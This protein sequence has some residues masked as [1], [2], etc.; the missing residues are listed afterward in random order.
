M[1]P[2]LPLLSPRSRGFLPALFAL[3]LALLAS[4]T[5][6]AVPSFARQTGADCAACHVGAYGPQ[7]TP[8]GIQFKLGGY[9]DTDGKDG[10]LPLSVMAVFNATRSAKDLPEDPGHGYHLNNNT[11]L[12]EASV[13]VAGRIAE[14]LGGFSQVT[15]SGIEHK[16]ALDQVDLR[17]ARNVKLGESEALAG[18]SFN[19]NPTLTDPFNSIGQWAFPYVESD[20]G[21]GQGNT[22]L[23]QN[24]ASTVMGLNAYALWDQHWYGEIGLYDT[25]SARTLQ[26][27]RASDPGKF[28]SPAVY[29]RLAYMVDRKR[30]NFSVGLV[31]FNAGLQPDRSQLGSA[32]RYSDVGVDASYQFLGNRRHVVTVNASWMRERQTLNY[33]FANL[34]ADKLKQTLDNFRLTTSYH[35]EQTWGATLGLFSSRGS[36]DATLNG[37]S[38]NGRPDT[39]GYVLQADWTPWGKETSWMSPLANARLGL[40]YTGY[41]RY[42]GGSNYFDEVNGV[43]RKAADNNTTMLFLWWSL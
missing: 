21:F 1:R 43:Q 17:F 4:P 25:L 37:S 18:V 11:A 22:P 32:D 19:T 41:S 42:M 3:G 39:T 34:G 13:F 40:Q 2:S 15:Y 7:L 29:W 36:A 10:K 24:L 16:W 35:Y 5:A 6:Q 28:K 9:S 27:I 26:R 33:S 23:V 8:F 20:F 14:N 38:L 12:Q 30:D 31:G